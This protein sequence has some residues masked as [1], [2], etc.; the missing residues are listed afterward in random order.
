MWREKKHRS[1]RYENDDE[2]CVVT[3]SVTEPRQEDEEQMKRLESHLVLKLS[4][5]LSWIGKCISS[6]WGVGRSERCEG[7]W[8]NPICGAL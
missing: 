2:I 5:D 7:N 6:K 4:G 8:S 3:V 1:L